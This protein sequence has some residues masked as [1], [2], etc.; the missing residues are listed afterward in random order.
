MKTS[1]RTVP[2][3]NVIIAAQNSSLTSP[4]RE[5]FARWK[6]KEFALL[7]S[8]DTISEYIEK[9]TERHI[10]REFILELTVTIREIGEYT[11]ID[12][13]HFFQYPSDPDDIAFVLCAENGNATHLISYDSHLLNLQGFYSFK[14]CKTVD[15][16]SELR[17]VLAGFSNQDI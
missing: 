9:L 1:L 12:S 11:A 4:N 8:D 13:F 14:I 7:F 3:T 16:L 5:Y 2:D 6:N 17:Q 15:F 10:S